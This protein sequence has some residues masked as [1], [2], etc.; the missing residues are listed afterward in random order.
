MKCTVKDSFENIFEVLS[1]AF[2]SIYTKR[3]RKGDNL[4]AGIILGEEYFFR[5][6]S[7]VAVLIILNEHAIS[8]TEIEII[9]C[10]SGSGWLGIS[11]AAHSSYAHD[12]FNYLK[13]Q[14]F[15]VIVED[16][17]SYFGRGSR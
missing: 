10:A 5:V 3:I 13:H 9:S 8:E 15:E 1:K 11:Y 16:E 4:Q 12:V 14:G 7:D 17:F 6:N 2:G